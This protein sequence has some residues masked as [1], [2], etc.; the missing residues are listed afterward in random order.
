MGHSLKRLIHAFAKADNDAVILMAK[1]D[2]QDG[3]WQ[4]SCRQGEEWNFCY[5]WPQA[6]SEPRCLVVPTSLQMGWVESPPYFFAASEMARDVAIEE[7]ETTTGSLP[8][9][10][11]KRWLRANNTILGNAQAPGGLRYVLEV[12][13]DYFISAIIPTSRQQIEHIARSILH[14]IHN[15]FPQVGIKRGTLSCSKN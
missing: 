3:F 13:V 15:V 6:P 10:K 7:I 12:Y 2:I 1:W 14:G 11:F 9:H 4:L 5:M 8:E